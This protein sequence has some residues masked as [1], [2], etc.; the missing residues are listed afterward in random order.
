MRLYI[1]W[2]I[3]VVML[4][5]FCGCGSRVARLSLHDYR[6][7]VEARRWLA[8]AEDEVSIAQAELDEADA[9]L[10][11][12]E[13]FR[14]HVDREVEPRW[15]SNAAANGA[16]QKLQQLARDRIDLAEQERRTAELRFEL[17]EARLVQTRAETAVRHDI[18]NYDLEPINQSAATARAAVEEAVG[19]LENQRGR[20]DQSIAAFWEAYGSYVRSGG[21]DD[22][23]WGW[24][25]E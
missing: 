18:A 14:T 9:R 23:L 19:Q 3:C 20:V 10:E 22:V 1:T 21:R 15:P 12:A 5:S 4:A 24:E 25:D 6:L 8:D 16:R 17:A 7:P 11:E 2:A 13:D